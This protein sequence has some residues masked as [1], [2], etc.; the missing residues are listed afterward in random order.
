MPIYLKEVDVVPEVA[1]F[2][3]ALIVPCRFCPA[4]S[5]AVRKKQPFI[6]LFRRLLK[7]KCYEDL[8]KNMQLLLEKEGVKT[9]VFRSSVINY[10]LCMW[11]SRKRNKLLKLASKYEAVVVMGCESAYESVCN[12]LRSTDCKIFHGME[13]EGVL[14]LSPKFDW[15]CNISFELL[16]VTQMFQK[17][18]E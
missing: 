7:T 3:S 9:R 2:Q 18:V 15:P 11:N 16:S 5:L 14:V 10:V 1:K 17:K 4:A 8:I 13:S 6:E 12:I